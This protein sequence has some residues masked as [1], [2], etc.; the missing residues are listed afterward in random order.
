MMK[1]ISI[2][3]LVNKKQKIHFDKLHSITMQYVSS[4][5][6]TLMILK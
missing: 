5:L 2:V 4:H 1:L 6:T 3:Y